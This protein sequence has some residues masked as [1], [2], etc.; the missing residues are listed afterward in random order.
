MGS[1]NYFIILICF[2]LSL[3][4]CSNE[5]PRV[6]FVESQ[7]YYD[8]ETK[9]T[10]LSLF[11]S[12]PYESTKIA[13][14]Q[15]NHPD[16]QLFWKI[17]N[18]ENIKIKKNTEYFGYSAFI[19]PENG[20]ELGKYEI[21]FFDEANRSSKIDFQL[22]FVDFITDKEKIK[23]LP[24]KES[25]VGVFNENHKII[26]LE[27]EDIEPSLIL[28]KHNNGVYYRHIIK[29]LDSDIIYFLEK[30]FLKDTE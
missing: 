9:T 19:A 22:K 29:D 17:Q 25:F 7:L 28:S 24:N 4:S 18:V 16:S 3:F 12:F 27:E 20:F 15:L 30:N 2:I 5:A 21:Q 10:G 1:K 14:I 13:K 23:H 26:A 6:I 8:T 11:G